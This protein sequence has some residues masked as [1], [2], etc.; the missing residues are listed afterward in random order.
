VK[1]RAIGFAE[2]GDGA[3]AEFAAGSEDA[4]G[5]FSAIGD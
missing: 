3:D 2:D 1:G 4:N 5:D